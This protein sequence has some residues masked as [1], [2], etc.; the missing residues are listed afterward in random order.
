MLED[1][2]QYKLLW[3]EEKPEEAE[4]EIREFVTGQNQQDCVKQKQ[5]LI[6]WQVVYNSEVCNEQIGLSETE[7]CTVKYSLQ[8]LDDWL[9]TEYTT[10]K[11]EI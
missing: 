11:A 10:V 1:Q 7:F 6:A 8:I 5:A 3:Y 2:E 4:Q 9:W